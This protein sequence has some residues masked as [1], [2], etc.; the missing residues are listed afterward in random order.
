MAGYRSTASKQTHVASFRDALFVGQ[1]PDGGLLVPESVP[2]LALAHLRG[3]AWPERATSVLQAWLAGDV[4]PEVVAALCA[5]AFD[6]PV[7]V[8]SLGADTWVAELFHGPTAAFKD[9][10]ARFMAQAMAALRPTEEPFTVLVATSGDTGSAVAQAFS[11]TSARV[12]LLYPAGRVSPLQ[13]L[14]LTA[15]PEN[16]FSL[17]VDGTFDDCQAMV[18]A[19]FSDGR[20]SAEL[21]LTS[22]NSINIGRLLPQT[23]YAVHAALEVHSGATA[24]HAGMPGKHRG[25]APAPGLATLVVPSGNLG[26]LTAALLAKRMGAP[27]GRVLAAVN[28]NDVFAR[29]LASGKFRPQPAV[30]TPSNAMDVG[31]PS[32][33]ER[34]RAL[35]DGDMDA[36]RRD[37]AAESIS[38]QETLDTMR[39]VY[40]EHGLFVCPHT[41]V[42]LAALQR[43]RDRTGDAAPAVVY[44]TAHPAKFLDVV[45]AATGETLPVPPPLA[46]LERSRRAPRMLRAD[47]GALLTFLRRLKA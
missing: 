26:N 40:L 38:D 21:G 44:A 23:T 14:Q 32:N 8:R 37:V 35:Y 15:V 5:R 16:A 33:A 6:F 46:A 18:R 45:F 42:G 17:C 25:P 28:S 22:A 2:Q 30:A 9:F 39:R 34:V 11:G 31:H 1:S 10:A 13:E 27:I 47:A 41:A 29:F 43:Y 4:A 20:A 3:A 36:L 24:P 7:P 12:V 19:A